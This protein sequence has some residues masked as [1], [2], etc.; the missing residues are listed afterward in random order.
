MTTAPTLTEAVNEW[1]APKGAVVCPQCQGRGELDY[2]EPWGVQTCETCIGHR[3]L[4]QKCYEV[5]MEFWSAKEDF[6]D[7]PLFAKVELT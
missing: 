2:G 3:F 5:V 1:M 7:L 6:S 4:T